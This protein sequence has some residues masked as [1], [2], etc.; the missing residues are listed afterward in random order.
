MANTFEA[1]AT[2]TVGSGGAASIDFSS[3][4]ATYTDL[5]LKVSLRTDQTFANS[6]YFCLYKL[7]NSTSNQTRRQLQG[8]GSTAASQS[9]SSFAIY[10]NPSD[11]T[12]STF[13]NTEF[14]FPDYTSS[15][16]KS[17]SIDSVIENNA[18]AAF[19]AFFAGLWSDAAAINQITVYTNSG[20]FVQ[21]S[22]ATLYG[23][24]NS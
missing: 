7:N 17:H 16:N 15:N 4:P 20:N 9:F 13:G 22:T 6:G 23:I 2:V 14:Y 5:L 24:K 21:H 3:I 1:I 10:C 8:D 12:A 11:Y 18:T 19:T